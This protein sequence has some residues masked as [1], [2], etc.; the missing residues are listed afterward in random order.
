MQAIKK[1]EIFGAPRRRPVHRATRGG[2]NKVASKVEGRYH[3]VPQAF[4]QHNLERAEQGTRL[5][6]AIG[7]IMAEDPES[8]ALSVRARL[9][10]G[11]LGRRT[12]P[13][14]RA[15]QL[16]MA[17]IRRASF[18]RDADVGCHRLSP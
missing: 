1:P 12:L 8:T 10:S 6:E 3:D 13:R 7:A 4:E 14:K 17:A 15:I 5:R 18:V 2:I 11:A 16:H 9:D